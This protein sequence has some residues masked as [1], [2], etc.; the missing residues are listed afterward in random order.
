VSR[1]RGQAVWPANYSFVGWRSFFEIPP[2]RR[3]FLEAS[4][5]ICGAGQ[6]AV[7]L[8]RFRGI[9]RVAVSALLAGNVPSR[10]SSGKPA[11]SGFIAGT[12]HDK[13]PIVS[14]VGGKTNHRTLKRLQDV[15]T[16]HHT[17]R[18]HALGESRAGR[19]FPR[20]L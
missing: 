15:L 8:L 13:F 5:L 6:L 14:V 1:S 17:V 2:F 3:G 20:G 9:A 16:V 19:G 11:S 7:G 12:V 18:G 10:S 4:L